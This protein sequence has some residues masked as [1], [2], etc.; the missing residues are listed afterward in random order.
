[1][2]VNTVHPTIWRSSQGVEEAGLLTAK[3]I[4]AEYEAAE[5]KEGEEKTAKAERTA[6]RETKRAEEIAQMAKRKRQERSI[7]E[8]AGRSV[9]GRSCGR[10]TERGELDGSPAAGTGG[11]GD[12]GSSWAGTV[13]AA[14]GTGVVCMCVG[15]RE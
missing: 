15:G 14:R 10:G 5:K 13:A 3:T 11:S 6:A 7:Y 8:A 1:M 4:L 2:R 12:P 9:H